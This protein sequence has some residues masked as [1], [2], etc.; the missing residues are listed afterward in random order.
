MNLPWFRATAPYLHDDIQF[1]R[2]L[3]AL[4]IGRVGRIETLFDQMY[5]ESITNAPDFMFIDLPQEAVT[6]GNHA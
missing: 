6:P 1:C 3:L 4:N 5:A 2:A